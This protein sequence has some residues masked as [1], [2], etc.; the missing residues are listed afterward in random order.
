MTDVGSASDELPSGYV[1]F[2][3]TDIEGSTPL[4]KRLGDDY[5]EVSER[6]DALLLAA[7]TAHGGQL[8]H[9]AGDSMFVAFRDTTAAVRACADAQAA[10]AG[11]RWPNDER[12]KVRMGLHVGLAKPR[13]GDYVAMAVNQAARVMSA[14]HGGQILMTDEVVGRLDDGVAGSIEAIGRYRLRDFDEP[15]ALHQHVAWAVHGES[16]V[17]AVPT[18][19]HNLHVPVTAFFDRERES[20]RVHTM[21]VPGSVVSLIGPGGVGKS[22]L[23][24]EVGAALA[25]EWPDGVWAADLADIDESGLVVERL[26][27]VVAV[28]GRESDERVDDIV[29]K[30]RTSRAV[31]IYDGFEHHVDICAALIRE[32]QRECPGVA[33]LATGREPLRIPGEGRIMVTPLPIAHEGEADVGAIRAAESTQL[34]LDRAS[35]ARPDL[36]F[37]EPEL[38]AVAEICRH[39]DGLPL[40]I[41]IAAARVD[42][43]SVDEIVDGLDDQFRLL[44]SRD[45]TLPARQRTMQGLLDWS[46]RLLAED[47]QV[48]LRRLAVFTG[49]F[50]IDAATTA[51]GDDQ[52]PAEDVE[53]MLWSL[54]DKSLVVADTSM[55]PTTYRLLESVQ[56]Y[57]LRLLREHDEDR[58]VASRV[59]RWFDQA[60]GP[61]RTVDRSWI[62]AMHAAGSNVRAVLGLVAVPEPELA[63]RLACSL[64][65]FHE[66]VQSFRA[67]IEELTRYVDEL[68]EPTPARVA[69]IAALADLWLRTGNLAEAGRLIEEAA[70]LQA[71]VGAPAWNDAALDRTRGDIALRSGEYGEAAAIAEAALDSGLSERGQARMW[72]LLG[73]ARV[74]QGDNAAGSAALERELAIYVTRGIE[75][76]TASAHGNVAEV[77][78]RTD[79]L[80]LAAEHQSKCLDLAVT[81]GQPV[82]LA[83]SSVV[84]A[85]LARRRGEWRTAVTL[86]TS[87]DA[88]L[89]EIGHTLYE[90]DEKTSN[91][92]LTAARS[93]LSNTEFDAARR[94]GLQMDPIEAAVMTEALFT[95]VRRSR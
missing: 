31:L 61:D 62:N 53:E 40:A 94:A 11:E 84:A 28:A 90:A 76:K 33:Q 64:G 6:H 2:V 22:R 5:V 3:F 36:V 17:R 83:Y 26:A 37:G 56:Q 25:P 43:M 48:A 19:G 70:T 79:D 38:H 73:I 27:D 67:G 50:R 16:P 9:T 10:L 34:F 69:L 82:M 92:L 91:A 81:L 21:L 12:L 68:S 14:A 60:I 54:N 93:E 32:I 24:T 77:A 58:S 1:T 74:S 52:V 75:S 72:N 20:E 42:V 63:Q 13:K 44:R 71:S 59:A 66:A 89:A 49:D 47:E 35:T 8:V 87:S 65:R 95:A 30:L 78:L 4:L 55:R 57:G 80:V 85:Q 7:F 23:A 46:T 45:R 29:D 86:Q 41:E 39:L 15:P 51:V 88:I 18:K